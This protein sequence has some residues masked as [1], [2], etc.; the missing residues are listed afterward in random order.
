MTSHFRITPLSACLHFYLQV[1]K[2]S[3]ALTFVSCLFHVCSALVLRQTLL[4]ENSIQTALDVEQVNSDCIKQVS[5]LLDSSDDAGIAEIVGTIS[6]L[7]EHK[8]EP[9]KLQSASLIMANLLVKSLQSENPVFTKVSQAVYVAA[10][11]VVLGG[12]GLKGRQ[13]AEDALRR[14]GASALV[15]RLVHVMEVLVM[16][17][18]VSRVVHGQWF[19]ALL[20]SL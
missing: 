19:E 13:L 5:D 17:A 16:T 18:A 9:E 14:I 15:D 1:L 4:S 3:L 8:L 10:R 6:S 20:G 12:T 7:L 2:M 11:G